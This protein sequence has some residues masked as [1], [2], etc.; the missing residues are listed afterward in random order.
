M[1]P[2]AEAKKILA[3]SCSWNFSASR[4]MSQNKRIFFINYPVSHTFVIAT[5]TDLDKA[6]PSGTSTVFQRGSG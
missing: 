6:F 3:P 2:S 4:T 5:K 1:R